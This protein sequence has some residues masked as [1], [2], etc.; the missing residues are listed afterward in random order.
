MNIQ[1]I[2]KSFNKHQLEMF[3]ILN[4]EDKYQFRVPTGVGKGYVMIGHILNSII[5]TEQSVFTIASHRLSLNNQHLRDLIDKVIELDLIGKV[6]FLTI[7]SQVLDINQL[8]KDDYELAKKFNNSLFDINFGRSMKD[9]VTHANTFQDSM[10]RRKINKIIK[11]NLKEGIRT[12]IITTYNSLD[13]LSDID[14][15]ITYLDE[16]HILASNKEESAFRNS[17]EVIKSKKKFFFT[18]TPKDMQA[19]I[20]KDEGSSDIFLM[21]NVEIFGES[22][23]VSFVESVRSG[24]ITEPII[25]LAYPKELKDGTNYDSIDNKSVFVKETFEAHE[26]WLKESSSMPDEIEAKMLVRCESVD[27]MWRMYFKL[28]EIISDDVIICAGASYNNFSGEANHVIGKEW[29]KNRDEFIKK[30]QAVPSNRKMII[31]NF[32]I[33]S[34]GLNV[35]GITGVMFLQG[36]MPSIPKVVQNVGRSTRLHPIDRMRLRSG[37]IKVGGEGWVKPNCAVII[38]YWD[39]KTG[40][41]KNILADVIRKLRGRMDFSPKLIL[42]VGDDLGKSEGKND[43]D[44]LNKSDKGNKKWKLIE[45]I[46]QEI[47]RLD[48]KNISDDENRR[49]Q[50]L[51][52][53]DLLKENIK[54]SIL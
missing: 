26:K 6:K 22:Y 32:D 39:D 40:L 15:D 17:F 30:I 18:A 42:S 28:S 14:I 9:H 12:I 19:E 35:S 51:S 48:M 3:D 23:E 52:K 45:G 5:N 25:H 31:L 8:F 34:E 4:N 33:F 38:P 16:A 10:D 13:K 41:V 43:L 53:L 7:G 1:N 37:E 46:N 11:K 21:N 50:G 47:E 24:Y 29:E 36:K 27:A 49:I 2:I 44:G 20:L 54:K